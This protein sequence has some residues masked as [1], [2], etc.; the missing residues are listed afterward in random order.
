MCNNHIIARPEEGKWYLSMSLRR[1]VT[2]RINSFIPAR[3]STLCL[4][5]FKFFSFLRCCQR[6]ISTLTSQHE[7]LQMKSSS[8]KV[9]YCDLI[10]VNSYHP[11]NAPGFLF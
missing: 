5:G 8:L 1:S 7:W 9:E 4:Q 10:P 11:L 2:L 3:L 6:F